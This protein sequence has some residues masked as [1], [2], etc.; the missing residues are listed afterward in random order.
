MRLKPL[1]AA[2]KLKFLEKQ[3]GM[4]ATEIEELKSQIAELQEKGEQVKKL[5]E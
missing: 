5:E 4:Y 2:M 3:V 1:E